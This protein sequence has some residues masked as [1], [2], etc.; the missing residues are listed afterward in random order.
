MSGDADILKA[1]FNLPPDEA[2]KYFE[3]KG[4]NVSFDW[5][6]MK[7]EA[8]TRAFTVAGVTQLDVLVDIRKAVE[9]A[10]KTGKSLES[11]KKELQPLLEKKGWWG[12][13]NI[14]RPDGSQ[15]EV[16]LSAP[17]RLKT[18]Y[19]T[20]MRTAAM[21]GHYKGM[22]DAADVMPYW[23]YVAV[24]DGRTR[25][26]HR[27]LHGKVLRHDD[28]FWD[29]YYPPNGWGC[30]CTVTAM[31]ASQLKRKGIEVGNGE[32]MAALVGHTVPDGWDYNPGKDAWLP[33]TKNYPGWAKEKVETIVNRAKEQNQ[34]VSYVET[35][36]SGDRNKVSQV[37]ERHEK[38]LVK[39]DHEA[40]VVVTRSGDVYRI[41]GK[42][43]SVKPDVFGSDLKG[44]SVTHNH[45]RSE[46]QNTFSSL[47]LELFSEYDLEILR[48]IDDNFIYELIKNGKVVDG[49]ALLESINSNELLENQRLYEHLQIVR[50]ALAG[51]FGYR[52]QKR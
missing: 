14:E 22:K 29:K 26:E 30:R 43:D 18:I 35:V 9:D 1:A 44:A 36:N 21:A 41:D 34:S 12:K 7:R 47:D 23:R 33:E 37:L 2:I 45:P 16:D 3:K 50:K 38:E 6:E 15:K 8:H 51:G 17:W 27:M 46:T 48:G 4:Y 31:T 25:D 10:Q 32:N 24:M 20:N 19:R 42:K 40:A 52:R 28:P 5:H 11:F 49:A 39:L 13:K